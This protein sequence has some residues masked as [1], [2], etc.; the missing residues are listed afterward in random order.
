MKRLSQDLTA[1]T[2]HLG[3]QKLALG[4]Y[5][6]STHF[7]CIQLWTTARIQ[8]VPNSHEPHRNS[9]VLELLPPFLLGSPWG[10]WDPRVLSCLPQACSHSWSTICCEHT[11]SGIQPPAG[12]QYFQRNKEHSEGI[13]G[14]CR[15]KNSPSSSPHAWLPL[16]PVSHTWVL[17]L[18]GE[19]LCCQPLGVQQLGEAAHHSINQV[20]VEDAAELDVHA[21]PLL[22]K[23]LL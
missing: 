15:G 4:H 22:S 20:W 8:G 2:R 16:A 10:R 3:S 7:S 23:L 12:A 18:V 11:A 17:G 5:K 9:P 19:D 21:G 13:H 6:G 1:L 14:S